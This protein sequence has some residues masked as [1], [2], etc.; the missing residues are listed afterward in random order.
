MW[1]CASLLS[2]HVRRWNLTGLVA[3][4]DS[5]I[6]AALVQSNLWDTELYQYAL[7]KQFQAAKVAWPQ[8]GNRPTNLYAVACSRKALLGPS[9]CCAWRHAELTLWDVREGS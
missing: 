7:L 5:E 9:T 6:H 3:D 2:K 4:K 1:F 8:D